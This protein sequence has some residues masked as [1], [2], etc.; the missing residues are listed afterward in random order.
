MVR[1]G[2]K[3][4]VVHVPLCCSPVL[5][6]CRL[7]QC[8][9]EEEGCSYLGSALQRN[10][11]HLKELDLSIN[12]VGDKGANQLFKRFNISNLTKLE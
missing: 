12:M 11:D 1:S 4:L 2:K 9:I 7:S 6:P 5:Y 10:P 3:V 8:R